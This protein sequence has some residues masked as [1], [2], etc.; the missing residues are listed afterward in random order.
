MTPPLHAAYQRPRTAKAGR[1][2][3]LFFRLTAPLSMQAGLHGSRQARH[4]GFSSCRILARQG[5]NALPLPGGDFACRSKD[6]SRRLPANVFHQKPRVDERRGARQQ[7]FLLFAHD[8][9]PGRPVFFLCE[10]RSA[11][12]NTVIGSECFRIAVS[13]ITQLHITRKKAVQK[14]ENPRCIAVDNADTSLCRAAGPSFALA[15][16]KRNGRQ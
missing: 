5:Q 8:R 9:A 12:G 10:L 4:G 15:V 13:L 7:A 14:L 2:R 6:S 11:F 16:V 1:V 3:E